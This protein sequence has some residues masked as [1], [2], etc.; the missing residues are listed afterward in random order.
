MTGGGAHAY[1]GRMRDWTA[2][3]WT[4]A[5]EK[6]GLK[7]FEDFWALAGDWV[8]TPNR[9]RG[10]W[11]GVVR[12]EAVDPEGRP[13]ALYVK[14]HENHLKR[15]WS[16]PFHGISTLILERAALGRCAAAGVRVPTLVYLAERRAPGSHRA[17]LATEELTGWRDLRALD[18]DW[19]RTRRPGRRARA[20]GIAAV[21]EIARRLHGAGLES[22][23]FIPRNLFL[24]FQREDGAWTPEAGDGSIVLVEAA[25]IDPERTTA[26][27]WRRR[28]AAARDLSRLAPK[29]LHWPRTDHLRFFKRYLGRDRLTEDDRRLWRRI[30]REI[31]RRR[32]KPRPW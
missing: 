11:S 10:G 15:V 3:D 30:A 1:E 20:A 22:R 12:R 19:R 14:L 8:E 27:R 25:L 6:S 21:A 29:F 18:Q 26:V 28:A 31:V 2:P 23:S 9:R 24:R 16:H 32:E 7:D 5:L 4:A 13:T 17:I